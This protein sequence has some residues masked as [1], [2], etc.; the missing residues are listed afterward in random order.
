MCIFCV[1][2]E[3]LYTVSVL[4]LH[5]ES[6]LSYAIAPRHVLITQNIVHEAESKDCAC[7]MRTQLRFATERRRN[8]ETKPEF[9]LGRLL[10]KA[11]VINREILET[12]LGS[13]MQTV[14][15]E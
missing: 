6:F 7:V 15:N 5:P 12:V 11:R 10:W 8:H 1:R 2:F 9:Q 3:R 14:K 4:I 13:A